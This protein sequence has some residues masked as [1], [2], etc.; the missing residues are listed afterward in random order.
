M[1]LDNM[2]LQEGATTYAAP[3]GGSSAT[4]SRVGSSQANQ[5]NLVFDGDTTS[6]SRRRV[7]FTGVE[8]ANNGNVTLDS[9]D[10]RYM[11]VKLPIAADADGVIREQIWRIE[12]AAPVAATVDEINEGRMLVS[13][14][15]ANS[16]SDPFWTIGDNA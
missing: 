13:Q 7:R 6:I 12:C 14:M 9:K 16:D 2:S 8:A 4:L 10:R 3:T 1:P 5:T 15:V 11:T